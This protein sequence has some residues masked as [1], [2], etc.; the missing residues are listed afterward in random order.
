[1]EFSLFA[2]TVES[3]EL[4]GTWPGGPV[5]MRRGD[6]GW[7]RAS[8]ELDDGRHRYW[9]RLPSQSSFLAGEMIDVPDPRARLVDQGEQDHSV[10]LI[11]NGED[12]TTAPGYAWRHDGVPLPQNDE[13]VIYELHIGEFGH[14]GDRA[15]TFD[16]V[17]ERLDY[18][19]DLG[20]TGVELMPVT[21]FP[22]E[23]SWGYNVRHFFALDTGYGDPT[24][25]KRLVD[26]CHGRGMRVVLDLVLNHSE[27]E[28]PLTR[29]DFDYWY[30]EDRE[31]ELSFGPKFDYERWDDLLQLV[32]AREFALDVVRYWIEEYHIDGY[33]LDATAVIDN[34]DIVRAVRE[35]S[36]ETASGKPFY[37]VAEQLPEDPA[38]AGP[39]G[40]ADGAWHQRFEHAVVDLLVGAEG[41][42]VERLASALQPANDGYAAP[43]LVVNYVE[44]HDEET[45]MRCLAEAGIEGEAAFRKHKLAA[46]LL[47][48]AV[49]IPMLYQGQEFGGY[50]ER[51]LDIRPLQWELLERDFG[52]HL[53]EHYAFLARTRRNSPALKGAE[54]EIL[55]VDEAA[56]T[57]VYRRG[58]GESE[59][60][61]AANL[62][63]EEQELATPLPAGAWRELI[64][65]Y[66]LDAGGEPVWEVFEASAAKLFVRRG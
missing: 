64:Y 14:L 48:T 45:L 32:P 59:V 9:F 16:T 34:F 33:R 3:V 12:V 51:G 29:I 41:A 50:R 13:L 7:W 60:I 54:L 61:V 24:S 17:V 58:Y 62:A 57:L 6:D 2:P 18:L 27:S 15:G 44:S 10:V 39:D 46:T 43:T 26:E 31:G 5:A 28:A 63:D 40:P 21:A 22:G 55:S 23:E 35:V 56:K 19:R 66:E 4:H 1:M 49:G 8:V 37:V 65:D 52:L 25:F 38:I 53:K 47:I 20:I 11:E 36:H 30:R 42:S